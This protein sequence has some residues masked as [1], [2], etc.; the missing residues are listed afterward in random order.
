MPKDIIIAHDLK[1]AT[2]KRSDLQLLEEDWEDLRTKINDLTRKP[3]LN[4]FM[5]YFYG[6]EGDTEIKTHELGQ[7]IR[8]IQSSRLDDKF[9]KNLINIAQLAKEKGENLYFRAD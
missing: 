7:L 1:A 6:V 2:T 3:L 4:R 5:K 8:E 9:L